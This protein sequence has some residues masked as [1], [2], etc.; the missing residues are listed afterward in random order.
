MAEQEWLSRFDASTDYTDIV[1]R[2]SAF[3]PYPELALDGIDIWSIQNPTSNPLV[4]IRY[5]STGELCMTSIPFSTINPPE[6]DKPSLLASDFSGGFQGVNSEM[7][8]WNRFESRWDGLAVSLVDNYCTKDYPAK[9][10]YDLL[11]D[12]SEENEDGQLVIARPIPAIQALVALGLG[13][14]EDSQWTQAVASQLHTYNIMS[15]RQPNEPEID[16]TPLFFSVTTIEEGLASSAFPELAE[17][18]HP[19]VEHKIIDEGHH[20]HIGQALLWF[21]KYSIRE[22]AYGEALRDT[23]IEH[24]IRVKATAAFAKTQQ[25]KSEAAKKLVNSTQIFSERTGQPIEDP[26]ERVADFFGL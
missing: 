11:F 3:N 16:M 14:A 23:D 7:G 20:Y 9:P 12:F 22:A 5:R 15:I 17:T 19:Y 13:L 4:T 18:A 26:V 10:I 8:E 25:Q 21:A 2:P 6:G 24:P 1:R